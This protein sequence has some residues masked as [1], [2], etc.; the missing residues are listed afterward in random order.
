MQVF[1]ELGSEQ[2]LFSRAKKFPPWIARSV[3]DGEVDHVLC[4]KLVG[5]IERFQNLS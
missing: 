5:G 3:L 4:E 1:V 2:L